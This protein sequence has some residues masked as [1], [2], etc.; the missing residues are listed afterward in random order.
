M[1]ITSTAVV[2]GAGGFIGRRVVE[3]LVRQGVDVI[4]ISRRTRQIGSARV[5]VADLSTGAGLDS[6]A[7]EGVSWVFHCAGEMRDPRLMRSLHV[8]GTARLLDALP[9]HA[10]HVR[11]IQLSSVGAYGPPV[12]PSIPRVVDETSPEHPQGEYEATKVQADRLVRSAAAEGAIQCV[13]LRP[14]AV[15]G[16]GMPNSSLRALMALVRRGR[17]FYPGPPTSVANYVHVDDVADALL[18]CATH[19][20]APGEIFN[21]S[22]DCL[23]AD[24]MKFV[25][26]VAGVPA[27]WFRVPAGP[28]RLVATASRFLGGPLTPA[29]VD[30]LVNHT[31]YPS[32]KI[33]RLLGFSVARPMPEG[34]RELVLESR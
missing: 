23:W 17:F 21:L 7:F 20:S 11:W 29:R 25:A 3:R 32:T 18:A 27:P 19:V 30:A 1:S 33:R 34:L 15:A 10:G 14:S 13:V 12:S 6:A 24:L 2:T 16:A 5:L 4:A 31:S 26:S 8:D 22:S 9:R 28:V